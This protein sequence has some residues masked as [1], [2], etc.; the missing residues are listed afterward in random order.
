MK[1][2]ITFLCISLAL[3][4]FFSG[5]TTTGFLGFLATTDSVDSRMAEQ[6]A[7]VRAELEKQRADLAQAQK[8]I[9]DMQELRDQAAKAVV[10]TE[11]SQK[12]VEELK[13]LIAELEARLI[14]M[15]EQTL[16]RLIDLLQASLPPVEREKK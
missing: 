1:R 11:Q 8:E 15:P 3:L 6:D 13:A 10:Q 7:M 14:T 4:F 2:L 12:S 9:R 5:C 16:R